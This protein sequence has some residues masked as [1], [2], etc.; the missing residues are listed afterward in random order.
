[1]NLHSTKL[2]QHLTSSRIVRLFNTME[3]NRVMPYDLE[4]WD[5]ATYDLE[6]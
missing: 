6:N 2:Q 5:W 3:L 1:M 4:N